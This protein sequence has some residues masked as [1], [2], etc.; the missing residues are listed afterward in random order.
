MSEDV[1]ED[2][3]EITSPPLYLVMSFLSVLSLLHPYFVIV[4]V[5]SIFPHSVSSLIKAPE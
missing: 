1:V 4:F 2:L 3:S 5:F